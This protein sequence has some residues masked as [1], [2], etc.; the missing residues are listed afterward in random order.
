M[1][2][3]NEIFNFDLSDD[4][5]KRIRAV[6]GIMIMIGVYVGFIA[7]AFLI[8]DLKI[9][10]ILAALILVGIG[11]LYGSI[12]IIVQLILKTKKEE[13]PA[14]VIPSEPIS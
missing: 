9:N 5:I 13:M 14:L 8:N 11:Q 7:L 4:D 3:L 10:P 1:V 12:G 2:K 6:L